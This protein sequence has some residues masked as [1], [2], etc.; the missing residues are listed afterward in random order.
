MHISKQS[1]KDKERVDRLFKAYWK[2]SKE[3]A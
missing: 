2:V 1:S 3:S